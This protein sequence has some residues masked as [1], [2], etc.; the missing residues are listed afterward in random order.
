MSELENEVNELRAQNK[1][2]QQQLKAE[3]RAAA[4][5]RQ[6]LKQQPQHSLFNIQNHNHNTNNFKNDENEPFIPEE[7][8]TEVLSFLP[9]NDLLNLMVVNHHWN[10]ICQNGLIWKN[11]FRNNFSNL[12]KFRVDICLKFQEKMYEYVVNVLPY[13]F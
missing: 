10:Y 2:L 9:I 4:T 12:L 8:F 6:Q 1:K 11:H 7:M 5:Q 13:V 3:R